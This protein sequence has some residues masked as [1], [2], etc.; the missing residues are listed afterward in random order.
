MLNV[1]GTDKINTDRLSPLFIV[2]SHNLSG[3]YCSSVVHIGKRRL[4]GTDIIAV[5]STMNLMTISS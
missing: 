5:P 1:E 3:K 2:S 4:S